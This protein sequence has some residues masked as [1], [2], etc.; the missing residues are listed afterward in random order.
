MCFITHCPLVN[1]LCHYLWYVWYKCL[2]FA[3]T[4][5]AYI[6]TCPLRPL[7]QSIIILHVTVEYYFFLLCFPKK[8]LVWPIKIWH[9]YQ[10]TILFNVYATV[11]HYYDMF[12]QILF[13]FDLILGKDA[14]RDMRETWSKT[15]PK[16][17]QIASKESKPQLKDIVAGLNTATNPPDG[18]TCTWKCVYSFFFF[19]SHN[20]HSW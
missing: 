10:K 7:W 1:T 16:I 9:G 8:F 11:I 12:N 3:S 2:N 6:V 19:W 15:F 17:L 5:L 4:S 13:E 18:K 20:A 14:V